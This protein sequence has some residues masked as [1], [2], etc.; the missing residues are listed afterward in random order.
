[1]RDTLARVGGDD[2]V[3]LLD[4]MGSDL[5]DFS[6]AITDIAARIMSVFEERFKV[7]GN[8]FRVTARTGIS[9]FGSEH[10]SGE[11][12][13]NQ[14]ESAMYRARETGERVLF[15]DETVQQ[16]LSEKLSLEHDLEHALI[17]G[18][19]TAYYQSQVGISGE[20][21]GFEALMRW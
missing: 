17:N 6:S 12:L 5:E 18:D 19:I 10:T 11:K 3:I 14:A 15:F 21:G 1:M 13:I 4:Q 2:F 8:W 20:V 9:L 16:R 7:A